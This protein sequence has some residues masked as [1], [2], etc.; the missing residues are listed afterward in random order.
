VNRDAPPLKDTTIR[1]GKILAR[2]GLVPRRQTANYLETHDVRI[3]GERITALNFSVPENALPTLSLVVDGKKIPFVQNENVLLFHKPT[4][5]VSSH[6]SQKIR[7]KTLPTIYD[8][9]PPKYK[10]WFFAGRL[11]ISSSGLIVLSMDGNHIY[12]LSHPKFGVTKVYHLHTSRPLSKEEMAKAEKGVL[13]KGERLRFE[14]ITGL[15]KPAHYEV[16]LKEGKNRE[17]R[18]VVEK[19]GV[20]V[21]ALKRIKLGPYS[22]DAL[23]P[24]EYTELPKSIIRL[25]RD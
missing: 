1:I 21:R 18:R 10:A 6:R 9:L 25:P 7:G 19:F 24:K 8:L 22:L 16:S 2:A 11:D 15:D 23:A 14:K 3:N 17:I 12:N 20:Y 13:D 5:V 4:G